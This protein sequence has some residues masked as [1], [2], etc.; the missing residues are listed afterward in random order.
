MSKYEG[1]M[2]TNLLSIVSEILKNQLVQ[3]IT[4]EGSNL[5]VISKETGIDL[6]K[7]VSILSGKSG[8]I[9]ISELSKLYSYCNFEITHIITFHGKV[10]NNSFEFIID[11][12]LFSIN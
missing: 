9:T 12:D 10:N 4:E 7:L 5:E 3:K 6:M 2:K 1:R 11:E 8:E